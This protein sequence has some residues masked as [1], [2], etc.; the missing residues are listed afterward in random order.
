MH[1]YLGGL[2]IA[3]CLAGSAHSQGLGV[4]VGVDDIDAYRSPAT[5]TPFGPGAPGFKATCSTV[6]A[7][8]NQLFQSQTFTTAPW[9]TTGTG[10]VAPTVT[11]NTT[12]APD[13]TLTAS[14]VAFP[15]VSG[16]GNSSFLYQPV[17]MTQGYQETMTL[18]VK[19]SG[20][21]GQH[22]WLSVSVDA[23]G[24]PGTWVEA[25]IV[26]TTAWQQVSI[27]FFPGGYNLAG[28]NF[29]DFMEIGID[30]RDAAQ[31]AQGAQSV[32]IWGGQITTSNLENKY[33]YVPT[34]TAAVT[35]NQT[36]NCP[37]GVAFR[38]WSTLTAYAGNPIIPQNTGTYNAGGVSNPYA[39]FG[40]VSGTL[41]GL[42]NCTVSG[43]NRAN[44]P[45]QCLY[46]GTDILHWT[47]DSALN[48]IITATPGNWDDHYL[49]H[50][51]LLHP[52]P[53]ATWCYY[54]SARNSTGLE[55]VGLF[56]SNNATPTSFAEWSPNAPLVGTSGAF[57][58]PMLPS[59]IS[60]GSAQWMYV[61]DNDNAGN[62]IGRWV[63]TDG[64][65]FTFAGTALPPPV[66]TAWD[67]GFDGIIDPMI[68]KNQHGFYE[69]VYTEEAA[70]PSAHQ[71]LGYAVSLDGIMWWE[72]QPASI[73]TH[74]AA[75]TVAPIAGAPYIGD[76]VMFEN[77]TTF[78]LIGNCDD[79]VSNSVGLAF[80]MTDH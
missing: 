10:A 16:A 53:A 48:P 21:G 31:S 13:S 55:S 17:A 36:I 56:L 71:D 73:L 4:G 63:A 64:I 74:A 8:T 59:V 79:G 33:S 2:L 24:N 67:G 38:D 9:A 20:A 54:F 3:L 80:T 45:N 11:A 32:F 23:T 61:A 39:T 68:F 57:P 12:T 69:M 78:Y 60:V 18:W 15:A 43:A 25:S 65:H 72:Y 50:G 76:G 70:T 41:Y 34:T 49:L 62:Q 44:W 7:I 1:K 66:G 51:S 5:T 27:S 29:T 58:N 40:N 26:T 77:G 75:C 37:A 46:T 6:F 22:I 19:G 35:Q 14:T 47:D 52:C 30:L 42:A 28:S